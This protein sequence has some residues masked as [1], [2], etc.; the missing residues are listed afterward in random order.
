MTSKKSNFLPLLLIGGGVAGAALLY[1]F[2]TKQSKEDSSLLGAVGVG[3]S[4]DFLG[5]SGI[6]KGYD[7]TDLGIE[8]YAYNRAT[9]DAFALPSDGAA[10]PENVVDDSGEWTFADTAV[11]GLT[12]AAAVPT[13]AK[14]V[15]SVGS[16]VAGSTAGQAVKSAGSKAVGSVA[17]STVRSVAGSVLKRAGVLGAVA[18][19]ISALVGTAAAPSPEFDT[20]A[21]Y[22]TSQSINT[23][24]AAKVGIGNMV[25]N[26]QLAHATGLSGG[27]YPVTVASKEETALVNKAVGLSSG[28]VLKV[29]GSKFTSYIPEKGMQVSFSSG[30]TLEGT[31]TSIMRNKAKKEA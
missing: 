9:P 19:G 25:T 20:S 24:L 22:T 8:D 18:T 17:G 30:G 4:G 6:S 2:G 31:V 23:D 21:I 7:S 11:V 12:A 27:K 3:G 1:G 16:K 14:A 26:R 5:S 13:V 10:N 29:S 28:D 15:K